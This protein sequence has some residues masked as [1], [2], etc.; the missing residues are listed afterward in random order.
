MALAV[1]RTGVVFKKC[2][3]AAHRPDSNSRC[4]A[5]TCQHSC[6][7]IEKCSRAWTLR[8][9]A[10]GKQREQSYR[11]SVHPTTGRTI[12]GSGRKLAQDAQ[13][14]LTVDKRAGDVTFADHS[15]SRKANFGD[16]CLAFIT[17]LAVGDN[18]REQ[19]FSTYRTHVKPAFGDRTLSQVAGDRDGVMDLVAITMKGKSDTLRKRTIYLIV[20]TCDEAVKAGKLPKH[21]LSDIET[22]TKGT[23]KSR[24]DFV[25]PSFAQ[26]KMVADGGVSSASGRRALQGAGICVWLM[27]GCGLRIEE[28]LSV[29]KS[30]FIEDGAILRVMWQ[31]TRD[32]M[33]KIPPKHRKQ[34]DYRDVPVPSW[35]WD[36]VK[37]MPEG[38]LMPGSNGKTYEPYSAVR[39]RFLHAAREAGIPAGF[40]AHSLRHAYASAMLARGV[41]ITELAMFLGHRNI[42]TT[43]AIYG[44][45]L[46][47]AAKR[48][49][50]ALDAEYA[51]W[52]SVKQQR[53]LQ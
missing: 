38:P 51:E 27:R 43:H 10:S 52:S 22:E 24:T 33:R 30:D 50:A 3:L 14:K 32:G 41:Q 40:T 7:N 18:S 8:Y 17:R 34:G 39:R 16:G 19:Y 31:S 23:L 11:D 20:G 28:A 6:T 29:E 49:V 4:T 44:H 46:P 12:Y 1:N 2:D 15:K 21:L 42:N 13:L 37:D 48:A 47:S 45:L 26:V 25:F 53:L 36:M 35:L 5:G 9:T